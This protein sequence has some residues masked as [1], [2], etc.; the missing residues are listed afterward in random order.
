M[1]FS[2]KAEYLLYLSFLPPSFLFFLRSIFTSSTLSEV[3]A[4]STYPT[5]FSFPA[6]TYFHFFLIRF[7]LHPGFLAFFVYFHILSFPLS[8]LF[9]PP[10]PLRP[11]PAPP[12]FAGNA[13][14][15]DHFQK[16]CLIRGEDPENNIIYQTFPIFLREVLSGL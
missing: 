8:T 6:P 5:L 11:S 7:P 9:S 2:P 12:V 3:T 4:R 16:I 1:P 10:L 15:A 13:G 14:S